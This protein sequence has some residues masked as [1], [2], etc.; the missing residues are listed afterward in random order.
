MIAARVVTILQHLATA[1][2]RSLTLHIIVHDIFQLDDLD[3]TRVA[4]ILN[5]YKAFGKLRVVVF[6]LGGSSNPRL[7]QRFIEGRMSALTSVMCEFE[8]AS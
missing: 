6:K 8:S 3:W 1:A 2:L 5:E 7:I 4:Q